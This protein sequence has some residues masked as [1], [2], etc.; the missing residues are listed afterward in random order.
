MTSLLQRGRGISYSSDRLTSKSGGRHQL[1]AGQEWSE[2]IK[3][4][5]IDAL[6]TNLANLYGE[7]VVREAKGEFIRLEPAWPAAEDEQTSR[8]SSSVSDKLVMVLCNIKC[9]KISSQVITSFLLGRSCDT[10]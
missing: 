1:E 3:Q 2:S 5:D 9:G 8:L 6:K 10:Y 4:F 7:A